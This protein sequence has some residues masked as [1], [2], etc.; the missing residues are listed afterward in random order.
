MTLKH[1]DTI[2]NKKLMIGVP[3]TKLIYTPIIVKL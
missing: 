3:I 1:N 2:V